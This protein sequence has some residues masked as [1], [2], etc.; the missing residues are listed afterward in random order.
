MKEMVGIVPLA[1]KG[2]IYNKLWDDG[3]IDVRANLNA[4]QAAILDCASA[5][6]SS[7]WV[8]ADYEQI[9]LLKRM[10]GSWVEDPVYFHRSLD[11]WPGTSKKYIPIFYSW[12]HQKDVG[13]RDSY[14]WGILNAATVSVFVNKNISKHII[15]ELFYVSFPFAVTDIWQSSENRLKIKKSNRF[16]YEFKGETILDNKLLSFAFNRQD[17]LDARKNVRTKGTGV[18]IR[19]REFGSPG[20]GEKLPKEERWSGRFFNL[21]DIFS[22]LKK[23]DFDA[24]EEAKIYYPIDTW[25]GYVEM[26]RSEFPLRPFKS[27]YFYNRR[28][29]RLRG[30]ER[31]G[32][33]PDYS[34]PSED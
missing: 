8:N 19:G 15:P 4:V 18:F 26:M 6:C 11:P 24:K 31:E 32:P 3:F 28:M 20:F 13:R 34:H 23:E 25:E 27:N 33:E 22:F 17:L 9:P 2:S 16:C 12:N 7:I 5:G 29:E 30:Y 1:K 14:G 21:S 10:V